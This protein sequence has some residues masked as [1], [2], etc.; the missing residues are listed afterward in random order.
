MAEP[1][2][3]ATLILFRDTGPASEHLFVERAATM[4]FAAGA[5]VFP[6]GRVDPG[7][8]RMAEAYDALDPDD[9]AARI[10][11]VRETIEEAGIAV[12]VTPAPT[13]EQVV[14]LR[15][16]L[17]AGIA[18]DAALSDHGLV[19]DLS[20]LTLF[21]RWC[22]NFA[23][24]RSFDTRFYLAHVPAG[25]HE[26]SVDATENVQLFWST[27][28]AVLDR[29][30]EGMLKIIFPTRRNLER[31]AMLPT[32]SAAVAHAAAYP[33]ELIVPRIEQ[34]DGVGWLTIPTHLGYPICATP[35]ALLERG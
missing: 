25:A 33:V 34:R 18:F 2:P 20:V 4:A 24:T 11:A 16:A 1:I 14:Q 27:A 7:D 32:F 35:L 10:A 17:A 19:L 8:R 30:A 29:A 9:A 21:A 12:G 31:L 26:A 23:E 5:I 13:V 28:A 3:A 6:G 22:P 15:E